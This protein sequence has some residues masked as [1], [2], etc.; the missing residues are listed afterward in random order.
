MNNKEW[1]E[2]ESAKLANEII[3]HMDKNGLTMQVLNEAITKVKHIFTDN[4]VLKKAN[5]S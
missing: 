5:R 1:I 2:I 3:A 4:A